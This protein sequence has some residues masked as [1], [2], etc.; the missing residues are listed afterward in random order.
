MDWR[1]THLHAGLALPSQG[2]HQ[3]ALVSMLF[4]GIVG[5]VGRDGL[6]SP[7]EKL[8]CQIGSLSESHEEEPMNQS[9]N[10]LRAM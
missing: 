10:Q 4:G 5:N 2:L 9:D 7:R 8:L 1:L 3:L 6:L